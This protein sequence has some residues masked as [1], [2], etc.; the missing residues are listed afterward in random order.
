MPCTYSRTA[1]A[2][3]ASLS[4][5]NLDVEGVFD[6]AAITEEGRVPRSS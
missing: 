2:N 4:V 6:S 5:D 3:D 1:I